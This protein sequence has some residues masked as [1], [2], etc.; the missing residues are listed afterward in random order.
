[1]TDT[2]SFLEREENDCFFNSINEKLGWGDANDSVPLPPNTHEYKEDRE[3]Y[4]RFS[5]SVRVDP[6]MGDVN[7]SVPLGTKR[8][9]NTHEDDPPVLPN[10]KRSRHPIA[11]SP[12]IRP[13]LPHPA[14]PA[15]EEENRQLWEQNQLLWA[16][17]HRLT[18]ENLELQK[19]L[20]YSERFWDELGQTV[21]N[22]IAKS[23]QDPS[24]TP[25]PEPFFST[26]LQEENEAAL[27][28]SRVE[29][30]R[31]PSLPPQ[32]WGH[33]GHAPLSPVPDLSMLPSLLPPLTRP[34]ISHTPAAQDPALANGPN[35]YW[36]SEEG[37]LYLAGQLVG[38]YGR[39][40]YLYHQIGLSITQGTELFRRFLVEAHPVHKVDEASRRGRIY[41]LPNRTGKKMKYTPT[42][43]SEATGWRSN[44]KSYHAPQYEWEVKRGTFALHKTKKRARL[45]V[46]GE[47]P[48]QF[49]LYHFW[50]KSV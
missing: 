35:E 21:Q 15:R 30:I 44:S 16:E 11:S 31:D 50:S 43:G 22:N 40:E 46:I 32:P 45:I 18:K 37:N 23:R 26:N 42:Q 14:S 49:Y 29:E 41:V 12:A 13:I 27:N 25:E 24:S 3:E 9:P 10:P 38:E 33:Y 20:E 39:A 8:P 34:T 7:D 19:K 1:M 6:S 28:V 48:P 47:Q 36:C 17:V 5:D 4:I 2:W